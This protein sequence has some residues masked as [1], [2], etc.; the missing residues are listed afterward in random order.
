MDLP[1]RSNITVAK[2][3]DAAD[4]IAAMYPS[5]SNCINL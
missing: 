5:C 3:H 2:A 4:A 1:M